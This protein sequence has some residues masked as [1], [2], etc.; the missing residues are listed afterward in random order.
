MNKLLL[1]LLLPCLSFMTD[2]YPIIPNRASGY[3]YKN[4]VLVNADAIYAVRPSGG[5]LSTS[6]ALGGSSC[7]PQ[8][9]VGKA[10]TSKDLKLK[11]IHHH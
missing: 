2:F 5:F 11:A 8:R 1:L 3:R 9:A 6:S 10:F 4:E 7:D